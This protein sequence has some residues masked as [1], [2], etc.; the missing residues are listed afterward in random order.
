MR[1]KSR[2]KNSFLN[3]VT[4]LGGKLLTTVLDF[5]VR[6][7]FIHTLGTNYLGINGL[8]TNILSMLSLANLGIGTAIVY[9][10]Y[11]PLAEQDEQRVRVLLKFYKLAYKLIGTIIFVLGLALI[12]FL[13]YLIKDYDTLG[14]KGINATVLFLMFLF[15]SASSYWFLAYRTSVVSANQENYILLLINYLAHIVSCVVKILVLLFVEDF[16]VYTGMSIL[17]SIVFSVVS[18][19]VA[20]KRYPQFFVK[21]KESLD[22]KEISDMLKDCGALFVYK[23][24]SVIINACDN[25]V[26]G[27]IIGLQVV[28]LY[29]NYL[30]FHTTCTS[31]FNMLVASYKASLGNLYATENEE[32]KIKFFYI[33]LFTIVVVMGTFG[34]GIA[35]CA[36]EVV[37]TWVGNDYVIPQPLSI[38]IGIEM[39]FGGLLDGL[40]QVRHVSGIF[41]QMWFR[42]FISMSVNVVVSVALAQYMGIYGV[43]IGT[44]CAYVLTNYLI[45]PHLIFK[46]A[47]NSHGSVWVYYKKTVLYLII[48]AAICALDMLFCNHVFVGH[49]WFSVIVHV[50]FTGLSVPAV[51]ALLFWK[52]DECR[53]LVNMTTN[54]LKKVSRKFK[55]A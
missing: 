34:V 53:Y 37:Q 43:I 33:T 2:I 14:E 18:G 44:I 15:N 51:F 52:T 4:G 5:I 11:K 3:L 7:V 24:N 1:S 20:K 8:F 50:I 25:L 23:A 21:E 12:P 32:T 49:G 31:F 42:P 36:D 9:R 13:K 38:L 45:D 27:A 46:Y 30:L 19:I 54:A 40:G 35:V 55:K 39:Y 10:M 41:R 26:L 22:R 48:L 6:T 47:F 16:I 28:G 29:S 17:I